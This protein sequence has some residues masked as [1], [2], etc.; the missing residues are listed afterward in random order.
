MLKR[1]D[2]F[3]ICA[4]EGIKFQYLVE[5]KKKKNH[6]RDSDDGFPPQKVE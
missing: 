2:Q 1:K 4:K 5:I 3:L 6:R